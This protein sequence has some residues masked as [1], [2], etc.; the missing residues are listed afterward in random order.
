MLGSIISIMLIMN[1]KLDIIGFTLPRICNSFRAFVEGDSFPS[2][3]MIEQSHSMP[4]G[5]PLYCCQHLTLIR[6]HISSRMNLPP[7][8]KEL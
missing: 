3:R 6:N 4:S 2:R 8:N 5:G 7:L 1:G